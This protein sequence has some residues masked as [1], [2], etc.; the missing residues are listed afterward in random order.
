MHMLG[1][2]VYLLFIGYRGSGCD[3]LVL[4]TTEGLL[5]ED[6]GLAIEQRV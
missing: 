2:A 6:V 5:R 1:A 4:N 3:Y